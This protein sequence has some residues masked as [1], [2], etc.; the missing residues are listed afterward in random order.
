MTRGN[1]AADISLF[2]H[3]VGR[4][5]H[6]RR[7][8]EAERLGGFRVKHVSWGDGDLRKTY[9]TLRS[10]IDAHEGRLHLG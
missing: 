10:E 2:D 6:G 4:D 7:H 8:V 1:S 5:E 3:L 9:K